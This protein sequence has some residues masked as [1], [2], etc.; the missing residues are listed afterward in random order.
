MTDISWAL[1]N[2]GL[3]N[4]AERIRIRNTNPYDVFR[5]HFQKLCPGSYTARPKKHLFMILVIVLK[6]LSYTI[7][8]GT[9][10][11]LIHCFS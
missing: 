9:F 7:V 5:K 10:S 1:Y 8:F 6:N 3:A 4:C 2:G 11:F